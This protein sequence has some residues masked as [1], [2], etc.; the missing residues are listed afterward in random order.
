M[1]K[2]DDDFMRLALQ[3]AQAAREAGEVPVGA[4][5]VRNGE[6]VAQAHNA[7]IGLRDPSAHAEILALRAAADKLGNY[8]LDDCTLY[9]T[10][11][12]C[13]MCAGAMAMARIARLVFAA[14]DPKGGAVLHGVAGEF[15]GAGRGEM[16]AL[17]VGEQELSD[18]GRGHGEGDIGEAV[19]VGGRGG[20]TVE[21]VE[22]SKG[23]ASFEG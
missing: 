16:G 14:C 20:E 10:L 6:V 12:P 3:Q 5:V 15:T 18:R 23:E 2:L 22:W 1:S 19:G 13:A 4:V 17:E 8:R 21:L 9:V 11:E 7:P